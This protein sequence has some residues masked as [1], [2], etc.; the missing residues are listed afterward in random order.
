MAHVPVL[1]K[2]G[3][4]K[5][6]MDIPEAF[7]SPV[8]KDVLY[9][10]TVMYHSSMRQG[11]ASTKN[12]GEVSGGGKKP[13]RQKGTGRARAGSTRSPL[14]VGGS[15]IFGPHPRDFGYAIPKKIRRLAFLESLKAKFH[16]KD[17]ICM[18]DF[19]EPFNKTKEFAQILKQLNLKGKILAV[20]D[21]SDPSIERVSRN[22]G[23]FHMM[24]SQDVN[25]YDVLRN[26]KVLLTKT[27]FKNILKRIEK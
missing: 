1:N 24:R 18:D 25:A 22:I 2:Q 20:L 19:K 3:A 27:A 10:A 16:Q 8:N 17:L 12:M 7:N 26:K 11:N 21:G 4:E 5:E 13:W 6:T 15:V 14:W 23:G 9:Q